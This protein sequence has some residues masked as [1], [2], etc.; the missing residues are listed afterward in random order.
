MSLPALCLV[1]VPGRRR[2]TIEL[3]REA[4]RRGFAGIYVPSMYGNM[5]MCEAMA[6]NTERIPFGTA[7]APIYAAHHAR[8]RAECG[9]DAR[10]L[11]RAL[12][13]RHRHRA[14]ARSSRMGV[15]PGK[16]LG[17]HARL[18]EKFRAEK[19]SVSCRRSSSRRCARRW[20]RWRVRSRRG[21]GVRQ[22]LA[23]AH[24]RIAGGA[25]GGQA[26]RSGVLHRQH[27]PD[28]HQR[29]RR[30]RQG[31]VPA[32]LTHYAF[33]PNY[34]NYWKEAGYV[35]EMDGDRDAPSPRAAATTCRSI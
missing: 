6:W 34:R 9:D 12:P 2:R 32:H 8:L 35:E 21:R 18:L 31:G 28:L 27:D 26:Q 33:L 23:L 30:G 29:R 17:R 1:A 5:S 3:A 16:P 14:R 7:I 19:A 24:G 25:A 10:G 11:G 13:P 4:E 15:T 22:C 20:W